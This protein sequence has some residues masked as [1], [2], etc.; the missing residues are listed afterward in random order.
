MARLRAAAG[1]SLALVALHG[2][3]AAG[4][5]PLGRA[6]PEGVAELAEA[7]GVAAQEAVCWELALAALAVQRG[8]GLASALGSD[9]PGTASTVGLRL[10]ST[11]RLSLSVGAAGAWVG[12]PFVGAGRG[13]ARAVDDCH[14]ASRGRRDR[15]ERGNTLRAGE[16]GGSCRST[17]RS[18]SRASGSP[19]G[20]A[21][22]RPPPGWALGGG[23]GY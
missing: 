1:V 10:G 3:G 15:G 23:S 12:R 9:I 6:E 16:S 8:V 19:G 2:V 5:L 11:P 7:C 17:P 21:S 20:R 4:Q 14:R 13:R 18:T 22:N